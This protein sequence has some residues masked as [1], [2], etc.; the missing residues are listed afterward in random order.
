M[1]VSGETRSNMCTLSSDLM[2]A[3]RFNMSFKQVDGTNSKRQ[4]SSL[5]GLLHVKSLEDRTINYVW[6]ISG[7]S[8][9]DVKG[10]LSHAEIWSLERQSTLRCTGSPFISPQHS[11]PQHTKL[12]RHA[13]Q[14]SLLPFTIEA[15]CI[16]WLDKAWGPFLPTLL[17][18]VALLTLIFLLPKKSLLIEFLE[19]VAFCLDSGAT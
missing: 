2:R 9:C 18:S 10:I 7:R 17:C 14:Q 1:S 11:I 5:N 15:S 12:L 13:L 8:R 19:F 6:N 4:P 16:H 3:H